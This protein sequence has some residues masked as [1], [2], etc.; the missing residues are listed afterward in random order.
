MKSEMSM[1]APLNSTFREGSLG[2]RR[3][4]STQLLSPRERLKTVRVANVE[5]KHIEP[6]VD[7]VGRSTRHD[8]LRLQREVGTG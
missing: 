6:G 8:A 1:R 3:H 2:K 4:K 7:F 5:N